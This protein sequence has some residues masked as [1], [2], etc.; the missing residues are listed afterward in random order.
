MSCFH[1]ASRARLIQWNLKLHNKNPGF[2]FLFFSRLLLY[3]PY[4][5]EIQKKALTLD[6]VRTEKHTKEDQIRIIL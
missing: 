2:N 6:T 3:N 5:Y 4:N 1:S